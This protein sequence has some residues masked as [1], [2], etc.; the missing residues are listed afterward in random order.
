MT[1]LRAAGIAALILLCNVAGAAAEDVTLTSRDGTVEISGNLLS[2]DGEFYRVD[3]I[4]GVLTVD[5]SGVLC[6]GPGCPDLQAFVA[7]F[8]IAGSRTMGEVLMPALVEA[9]AVQNDYAVERSVTSDTEFGY[10]LLEA[11]SGRPAA[12]IGFHV[13]STDE[14]FA[15]LFADEADLVLSTRPVTAQEIALARDAGIG[16]LDDPRRSRIIG[17]DALVPVV[18]AGNPAGA[19]SLET[20][21]AIFAGEVANW[22]ALGGED[23][24]IMLHLRDDL[25]GAAQEFRRQVLLPRDKVLAPS[26]TRHTTNLALADAVSRDPHAFGIASF[27]ELGATRALELAG[28]CR[29]GS[30]ANAIS[31]KT[32]DYPLVTPL[33]VYTPGR[34]LPVLAREFLSFIRS[35]PAQ[36]VVARSGF[37]NLRLRDI[38]VGRQGARLSSAVLAAGEEIKLA[39]VQRLVRRMQ[40][41]ARLTLNFRFASGTELDAQ[42]R[43]NVDILA[44]EIEAGAFYSR[45]LVFVGFSDGEGDAEAN[46]RLARIRARAVRNAVL[47]SAV[48]ADRDRLTL[49]TDAF[50]EAMPLACNDTD[51]GRRINRRVEVWVDQR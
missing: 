44:R 9:F 28:D 17:L 5:G 30:V 26:V 19:M 49:A 8:D 2:F 15:D 38:P 29:K 51:W 35:A 12:Q 33:F 18:A 48:T 23:A 21:A 11:E 32:Q 25:S 7:E 42:S 47:R 46:L 1:V 34:R 14:G 6:D 3:T 27:S 50:G 24:P 40:G 4:Y 10:T 43:S 45:N 37:V 16:D 22:Q 41:T 39:E 13:T 36:P 31:I 20:L